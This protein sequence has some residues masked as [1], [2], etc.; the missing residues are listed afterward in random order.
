MAGA[1]ASAVS[2]ARMFS[3]SPSSLDFHPHARAGADLV[4]GH[5]GGQR[6]RQVAVD[7]AI[8][9]A[10]AVFRAGA[11]SQQELA[12]FEGHVERERAIAEP[13]IDVVL[14]V[15]D[16]LV[17]DGRERFRRQRLVGD[18]AID[19]VDELR[20]EALAHRHQRDVLQLAGEVRRAPAV[21]TD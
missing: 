6:L 9:L 21:C 8:Q 7:R 13:R 15:G 18:D 4:G 20:R 14:Q 19:A 16:L 12:R 10:R 2:C 11:L 17:Q 1:G 5:H 3:L